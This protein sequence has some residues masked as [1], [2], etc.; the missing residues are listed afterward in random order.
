MDGKRSEGEFVDIVMCLIFSLTDMLVVHSECCVG[1]CRLTFIKFYCSL[2]HT[3]EEVSRLCVCVCV[4]V[5]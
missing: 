4:V 3:L 1:T 5:C 2:S